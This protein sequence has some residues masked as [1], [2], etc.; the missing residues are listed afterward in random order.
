MGWNVEYTG[1]FEEWWNCLTDDQ[2]DDFAAV[3]MLLEEH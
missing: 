2:Q 3:V 1:E